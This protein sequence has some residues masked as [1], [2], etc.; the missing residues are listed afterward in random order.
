M[1][2]SA[3]TRGY[4]L[5]WHTG[6]VQREHQEALLHCV[7]DGTVAQAAQR[8]WRFLLGDLQRPPGHG[9]GHPALGVP[10]AAGAGP[11]GP[12]VPAS[13]SHPVFLCENESVRRTSNTSPFKSGISSKHWEL[14]LPLEGG[15]SNSSRLEKAL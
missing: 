8:L 4:G 7:A 12:E 3:C 1:A 11:N 10:V 13:L 9:P 6:G 5:N 15:L 2:P 14:L